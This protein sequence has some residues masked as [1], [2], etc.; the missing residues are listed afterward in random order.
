M[1]SP[2]CPHCGERLHPEVEWSGAIWPGEFPSYRDR[3]VHYFSCLA[4]KIWFISPDEMPTGALS[5]ITYQN[6]EKKTKL[7]KTVF[8]QRSLSQHRNNKSRY[9]VLVIE[10]NPTILKLLTHFF[11]LKAVKY[12]SPMM[13]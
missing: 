12:A 7:A 13:T 11:S 8:Q 5:L 1:G 6:S 3:D 4:C 2:L 9:K 10:N